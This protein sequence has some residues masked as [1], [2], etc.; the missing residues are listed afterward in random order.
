MNNQTKAKKNL[1][2]EHIFH[3]HSSSRIAHINEVKAIEKDDGKTNAKIIIR[4]RRKDDE[5]RKN[6]TSCALIIDK[7]SHFAFH[8]S[9]V[10]VYRHR[11]YRYVVILTAI[12][13]LHCLERRFIQCLPCI[14]FDLLF[15]RLM[16]TNNNPIDV[17]LIVYNLHVATAA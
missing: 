8:L 7:F 15:I 3:S 12:L 9:F 6:Y 1:F 4:R 11:Y 10:L 5:K 16:F 2:R 17:C 13:R 14:H